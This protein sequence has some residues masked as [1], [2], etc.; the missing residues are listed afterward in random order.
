MRT[1]KYQAEF[2]LV[3]PVLL[4]DAMEQWEQGDIDG[5]LCMMPNEK[6][7]AFVH[8]NCLALKERGLFEKALIHAYTSTRTNYAGW[9]TSDLRWMFDFA[10]RQ[11]LRELAPLPPGNSF[12]LYRGVAGKGKA[13]RIRGMSWT[14]NFDKA[15]WFAKR[16]LA[17]LPDPAIYTTTAKADDI[18]FFDDGR[19]ER[20]FILWAEKYKRTP[21]TP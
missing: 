10:D 20:D 16:H 12:T 8:D 21:W 13:R 19:T 2:G 7:M 6:N 14:D 4:S 11:K 3:D 5:V 18:L 9:S 17:I 15:V 1:Y